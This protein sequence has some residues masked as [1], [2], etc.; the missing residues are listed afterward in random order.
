MELIK[1][2][3][4]MVFGNADL[5]ELAVLKDFPVYCGATEQEIEKDLFADMEW[6]ISAASGMVQLCRLVPEDILYH[7]SHNNSIGKVWLEHH[8]QFADFLHKHKLKKGIL[9][10][11]GGNGILNSIYTAKYGSMEW[12]IIEPSSV[13]KADGCQARYINEFWGKGLDIGKYEVDYDVLVHSHVIEHQ[14]DLREFMEQNR[15]VLQNG[16]RMIFSAPNMKEYVERKYPNALFFEHTY[17]ITEDYIE[18]MLKEYG[19]KMIDKQLYRDDHSIFYAVEKVG[20]NQTTK[21]FTEE[22]YKK[23]YD[24]NKTMFLNYIQYFQEIVQ[25]MNDKLG[26]EKKKV[27]LFGAHIFSQYLINFGLDVS[28]IECILDNDKTKQ[29]KRLYGTSLYVKSPK[30]LKDLEKPIVILKAASYSE[31]IQNDIVENINDK[32]VFWM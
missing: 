26:K 28:K 27:Y 1:R 21:I 16:D 13:Y 3:K 19:F 11:G 29:G 9:E 6:G 5:E 24:E 25:D 17:L 31:E 15:D 23:L 10:I 14:L 2:E 22:G 8:T 20:N 7:Q 18:L 30:V 12:T 4:D 32:A